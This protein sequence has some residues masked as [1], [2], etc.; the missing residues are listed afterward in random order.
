M[1]K[2][3]ADGEKRRTE[4]GTPLV[5]IKGMWYINTPRDMSMFLK[6]WREVKNAK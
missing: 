4:D 5:S 6:E 3:I 2:A 1:A